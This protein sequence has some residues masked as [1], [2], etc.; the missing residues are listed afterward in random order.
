MIEF[1]QQRIK[2]LRATLRSK[3]ASHTDQ[4]HHNL[5]I[6]IKKLFVA[7]TI[8]CMETIL[9][10]ISTQAGGLAFDAAG[11]LFERGTDSIFKFTPD[12]KKSTFASGLSTG[13]STR[14]STDG[15]YNLAFD[16]AGDLFV[17]DERTATQSLNSRRME[18]RAPS[19]LG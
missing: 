7:V 2:Q 1:T 10:S 3:K 5:N 17:S 19:H 18:R 4:L 6:G 13:R 16:A 9:L 12:G 14:L 11:N 15:V 8:A